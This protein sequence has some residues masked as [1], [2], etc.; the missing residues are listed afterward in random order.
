MTLLPEKKEN[1]MPEWVSVEIGIKHIPTAEKTKIFLIHI[2]H[3]Y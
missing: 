2:S 1:K 3:V